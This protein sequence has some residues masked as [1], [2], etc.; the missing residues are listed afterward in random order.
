[1]ALLMG[2]L[3]P[4]ESF[5]LQVSFRKPATNHMAFSRKLTRIDKTSCV[6]FMETFRPM[7]R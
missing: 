3:E 6:C 2:A 4:I 1:M 7:Q 5:L